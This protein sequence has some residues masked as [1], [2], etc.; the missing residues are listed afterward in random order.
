[1][2][3]SSPNSPHFIVLFFRFQTRNAHEQLNMNTAAWSTLRPSMKRRPYFVLDD[4]GLQRTTNVRAN[5]LG[6]M[7]GLRNSQY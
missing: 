7:N 4:E 5:K 2:R 6:M 3:F 1:M